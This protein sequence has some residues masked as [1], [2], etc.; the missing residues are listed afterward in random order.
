ME[1]LQGEGR[2]EFPL[3]LLA[4]FDNLQLTDL[5]RAG[6]AGVGDVAFDFGPA[7]QYVEDRDYL[8]AP[9]YHALFKVWKTEGDTALAGLSSGVIQGVFESGAGRIETLELGN[10]YGHL[11]PLVAVA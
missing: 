9:R 8:A 10:R 1:F 11:A 6:L 3:R 2:A 5:V 4:Q 7:D